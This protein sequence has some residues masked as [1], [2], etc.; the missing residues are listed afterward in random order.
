MALGFEF[1]Y[2]SRKHSPVI[3][4]HFP[5]KSISLLVSSPLYLLFTLYF[6]LHPALAH[7][8]LKGHSIA[9]RPPPTLSFRPSGSVSITLSVSSAIFHNPAFLRAVCMFW[10]SGFYV[11]CVWNQS[12][13]KPSAT[14]I[15]PSMPPFVHLFKPTSCKPRLWIL[16][17]WLLHH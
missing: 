13:V 1:S 15:Q 8:Y 16:S 2:R 6:T 5:L 12:S 14:D 3:G 10:I 17:G 9:Q 11:V 7:L 4:L